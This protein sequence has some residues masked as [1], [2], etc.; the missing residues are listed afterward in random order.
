MAEKSADQADQAFLVSSAH[1]F[2]AGMHRRNGD[3]DIH[4]P[5]GEI[6]REQRAQGRAAGDVRPVHEYLIGNF[7]FPAQGLDDGHGCGIAGI[8]LAAGN[9][10]GDA[11]AHDGLVGDVAFFRHVGMDGVGHVDGEHEG[12]AQVGREVVVGEAEGVVDA[13]QDARQDLGVRTLFRLAADFFIVEEGR[14]VEAVGPI[15]LD[16]PHQAGQDRRQVVQ[17][18][19][20][21]KFIVPAQGA[22]RF[23]GIDRQVIR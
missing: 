7:I 21:D 17:P 22:A 23:T 2:P 9:L 12:P 5:Q 6:G 10:Q 16:Q 4:G 20:R 13:A 3:A 8:A 18:R 1:Q 15:F 14:H 19:R 11:M